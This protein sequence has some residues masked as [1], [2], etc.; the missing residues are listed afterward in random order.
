MLELIKASAEGAAA[1][2]DAASEE[3][4]RSRS[5]RWL[6]PIYVGCHGQSKKIQRGMIRDRSAHDPGDCVAAAGPR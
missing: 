5:C 2:D 1:A 4:G 3:A 6:A